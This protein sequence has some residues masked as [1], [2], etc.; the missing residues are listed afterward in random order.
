MFSEKITNT[1]SRTHIGVLEV[2][3]K[4]LSLI[5]MYTVIYILIDQSPQTTLQT[6]TVL[7]LPI[8]V[9]MMWLIYYKKALSISNFIDTT[10]QI[11]AIS[12]PFLI[13]FY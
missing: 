10:Y 4:L 1:K 6:L 9:S 13:F 5:F 2:T 11:V 8:I 7:L 12:F 3:V